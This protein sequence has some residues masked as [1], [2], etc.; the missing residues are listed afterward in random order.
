MVDRVD[1][2]QELEE[3]QRQE[4]L[5]RVLDRIPHPARPRTDEPPDQPK[6]PDAT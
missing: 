1:I 5:R 4:A 6:E 2:A 3:I